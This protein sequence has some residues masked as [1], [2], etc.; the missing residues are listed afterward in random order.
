M[1]QLSVEMLPC[2]VF[3]RLHFLISSQKSRESFILLSSLFT[4]SCLNWFCFD[5]SNTLYSFLC[6]K[7]VCLS[8]SL[9]VCLYRLRALLAASFFSLSCWIMP[10]MEI[11]F[12]RDQEAAQSSATLGVVPASIN[13]QRGT[14]DQKC[15][16]CSISV[17]VSLTNSRYAQSK[18]GSKWWLIFAV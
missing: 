5:C 9:L 14:D 17:E 3:A 1:R 15:E 6:S 2:I 11:R 16:Q 18:L 4:R 12:I 10:Q 7:Y 13:D 8:S